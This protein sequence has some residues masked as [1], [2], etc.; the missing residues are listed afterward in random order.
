MTICEATSSTS[1]DLHHV[2][3]SSANDAYPKL[4]PC[5]VVFDSTLKGLNRPRLADPP[6]LIV[7]PL[8]SPASMA[9]SN[10]SAKPA[11]AAT[12]ATLAPGRKTAR[13]AF[14]NSPIRNRAWQRKPRPDSP[15]GC[16]YSAPPLLVAWPVALT[17]P[18]RI[19]HPHP[20][21]LPNP[22]RDLALASRENPQQAGE[23][24][25]DNHQGPQPAATTPPTS[26]L[27]AAVVAH[28]KSP[29]PGTPLCSAVFCAPLLR[30]CSHGQ[31][32]NSH[33]ERHNPNRRM[34]PARREAQS[35]RGKSK[36]STNGSTGCRCRSVRQSES[37]IAAGTAAP[38]PHLKSKNRAAVV[39]ACNGVT[40]PIRPAASNKV[41]AQDAT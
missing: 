2:A 32:S 12:L 28:F 21:A 25:A 40:R 22:T 17:R 29:K 11:L 41:R 24:R 13:K 18:P 34:A 36:R 4:G 33:R 1:S 14:S 10:S 37:R 20:R 31:A 5:F 39:A 6:S 8:N 23:S 19:S 26:P 7:Q 27:A 38:H 16:G 3:G 35:K 15:G 30:P 9:N